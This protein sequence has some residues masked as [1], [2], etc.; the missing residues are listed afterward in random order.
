MV[1]P[2]ESSKPK[3]PRKSQQMGLGI[4]SA[5]MKIKRIEAERY[6]AEIIRKTTEKYAGVQQ[7]TGQQNE[8]IGSYVQ[9][10]MS[11]KHQ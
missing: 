5:S 3:N 7:Q 2:S 11:K 8:V 4:L 10:A 6:F 9:I 1:A